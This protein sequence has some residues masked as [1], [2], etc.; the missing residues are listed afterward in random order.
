[1]NPLPKRAPVFY[2]LLDLYWPNRSRW[3][4]WSGP[5]KHSRKRGAGYTKRRVSKRN[6]KRSSR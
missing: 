3:D 4:R 6:G 5:A 2:S 1:M